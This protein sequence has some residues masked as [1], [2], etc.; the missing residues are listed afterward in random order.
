[1]GYTTRF[2]GEFK[3][4]TLPSVKALNALAHLREFGTSP[5]DRQA[6]VGFCQWV[7]TENNTLKWDGTEKFAFY[8]EWLQFVIDTIFKPDRVNILGRVEYQGTEVGDHGFLIVEEDQHVRVQTVVPTG[9]HLETYI[10]CLTAMGFAE[11][12][13]SDWTLGDFQYKVER[14]EESTSVTIGGNAGYSGFHS[15]MQFD[16]AG[17]LQA[18]GAAE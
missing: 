14:D 9:S 6:P 16:T 7:T 15:F 13:E 11:T 12:D 8:V 5:N 18:H 1:M 4:D 2:T 10:N 17:K 3:L